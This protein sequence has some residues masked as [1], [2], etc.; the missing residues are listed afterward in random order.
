MILSCPIN[1]YITRLDCIIRFLNN[2]YITINTK[3]SYSFKIWNIDKSTAD[4]RSITATTRL[5]WPVVWWW[6]IYYSSVD[7][8]RCW[9]NI[10]HTWSE[11]NVKRNS[12]YFHFPS[13]FQRLWR[14]NVLGVF[15]EKYKDF[16]TFFNLLGK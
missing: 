3:W 4:K 9:W 12:I 8:H 16:V 1:K 2:N 5:G 14:W 11:P 15:L 10:S 6:S 7:W 13:N